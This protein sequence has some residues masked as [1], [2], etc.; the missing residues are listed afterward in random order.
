[1]KKSLENDDDAETTIHFVREEIARVSRKFSEVDDLILDRA[2]QYVKA[3]NL[4]KLIYKLPI[5]PNQAMLEAL[6]G[7]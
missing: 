4:K 5:K 1:M 3:I 7:D 6:F 2:A